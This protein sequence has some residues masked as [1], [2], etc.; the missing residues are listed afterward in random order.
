MSMVTVIGVEVAVFPAASVSVTVMSQSPSASAV[1]VHAFAETVHV[2]VVDPALV[3]V[4]TAVP[5]NGP[6][7]ENVGVLSLVTLSLFE[8]PR[9]EAILRSAAAGAAIGVALIT[10]F[11]S[12]LESAESIPLIVCFTLTEYVPLS[13]VAKVQFSLVAVAT[14]VHV[15]AD[16][17][18]G[19]AVTVI[20]AP[21]V[22]PAKVNVGVA[23]AVALSVFEDP[24][25]EAA[26]RSGAGVGVLG[27]TA[28]VPVDTCE[29]FPDA[30]TA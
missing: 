2:T 14:K 19:V 24:V 26:V 5:A 28:T 20:F 3:A 8:E 22:N 11:A 4:K 10:T 9:S 29:K 6:A 27:V 18:A 16:P 15:T 23:S 12:E 7:I 30:S 17:V 25:S 1:V 13:I 21:T